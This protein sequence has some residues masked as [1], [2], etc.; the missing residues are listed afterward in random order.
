VSEPQNPVVDGAIGG[1]EP[2][3][4]KPRMRG[5]FHQ[6]AFILSIPAGL[7]LVALGQTAAARASATIYAVSL[8]ALLGTSAS[9]HRY[10]WSP[11]ALTLMQRLDHSMIFLLIAGTYTPVSVLALDGVTRVAVLVTVWTGAAVGISLKFIRWRHGPLLSAVLYIGLGWLVVVATPQLI[12]QL[13]AGASILL[14]IGGVLY[15]TGAIVLLRRRPDPLPHLFGY[16]EIWHA[17][18]TGAI[19][20]HYL[21]ILLVE[22]S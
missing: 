18:V 16:H 13:P 19:A 17:M 2:A 6:V 22:I 4:P 7:V 9:Y 14:A 1:A 3:P 12:R 5:R 15:T 20:C 8:A 10:P 11:R 21:A